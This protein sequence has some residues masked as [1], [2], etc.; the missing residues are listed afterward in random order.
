M[1]KIYL[2]FFFIHAFILSH[3]QGMVTIAFKA[4]AN[5]P[6]DAKINVVIA[7]GEVFE[8]TLESWSQM[9]YHAGSNLFKVNVPKS[10][11]EART[12]AQAGS[13]PKVK[14]KF[15]LNGD[16]DNYAVETSGT[17][18]PSILPVYNDYTTTGDITKGFIKSKQFIAQADPQIFFHENNYYLYGTLS[19]GR[20]FEVYSSPDLVNWTGPCGVRDGFV[21]T[22]EDAYGTADY[23]APH[24]ISKNGKIIMTYSA[25]LHLALAKSDSPLGPFVNPSKLPLGDIE[26]IDSFVFTDDDGQMYMYH[27][28]FIGGNI[29]HVAKMNPDF[30][31]QDETTTLCVRPDQPW[32]QHSYTVTEG[33]SVLKHNNKY[34]LFY[35]AN[36][37]TDANYA[38]GY[39]VSDSPMGPWTKMPDSPIISRHNINKANGVEY[40]LEGTGHGDFFTAADGQLYYCFHAHNTMTGEDRWDRIA[41]IAK[42]DFQADGT[43]LDKMV[44]DVASTQILYKDGI[45]YQSV[46]ASS[47]NKHIPV[48]LQ[49]TPPTSTPENAEIHVGS[50]NNGS[51][52]GFGDIDNKCIKLEKNID[53]KYS[54]EINPDFLSSGI[55]FVLNRDVDN[56]AQWDKGNGIYDVDSWDHNDYR[57]SDDKSITYDVRKFVKWSK[58]P[59]ITQNPTY[60]EFH[61]PASTPANAVIHVG[62]W[63]N[64]GDYGFSNINNN[65]LELTKE[66]NGLYTVES[67]PDFAGNALRFILNRDTENI[68]QW[69]KGNDVYDIDSWDHVRISEDDRYVYSITKFVKWSKDSTTGLNSVSADYN[70]RIVNNV[71]MLRVENTA[72]IALTDVTGKLIVSKTSDQLNQALNSGIYIL[73]IVN[74]SKKT[75]EKIF[76]R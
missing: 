66:N 37:Y 21:M 56:I 12:I 50:W 24:I 52:Y 28:R 9:H 38:M 26:R 5:T 39:A 70:Y 16:L 30:S 7:N 14:M 27:S 62:S 53:G 49:F 3:A 35:S 47:W 74:E 25:N 31:I 20:G 4:P 67:D 51:D 22:T 43:G 23:W 13:D 40:D 76:I 58:D 42:C 2:C 69:Y 11:L 10:Y 1:R 63:K 29:I 34:Y 45:D 59:I 8:E 17:L 19:G 61:A 75:V 65:C 41:V 48:Y 54:I 55:R 73:T 72:Q 32:E 44:V 33:P 15:V 18:S 57:I 71:L 36:L 6:N 64:G 60:I 68:A 46:T